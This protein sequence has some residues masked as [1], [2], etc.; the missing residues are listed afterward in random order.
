MRFLA[1][2][3]KGLVGKKKIK[4]RICTVCGVNCLAS[5]FGHAYC[6]DECKEIG[7]NKVDECF[8]CNPEELRIRVVTFKD[9]TIH[10]QKYCLNCNKTAFV[11]KTFKI[12]TG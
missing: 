6:S 1:R 2:V 5:G 12:N 8:I 4:S 10:N 7:L 9:G 3:R 11:Q